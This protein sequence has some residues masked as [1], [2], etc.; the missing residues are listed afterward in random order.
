MT[1]WVQAIRQK[2]VLYSEF[3]KLEHTLFALPFALSAMVLASR[4]WPDPATVFWVI[5]AM[6]G[7]RTYAM[8]VNRIADAAL[9]AQNPRTKD[10]PLPSGRMDE[11]EAWTL[12]LSGLLVLILAVTFLPPICF[13]LLPVAWWILTMYSFTKRFSYLSHAVLGL[14]LGASAIGGW[15]AVE[16]QWSWMAVLFGLAVLF[17]VAGFDII[18]ACLDTRFDREVGLQ[19]VPA[20]F[21]IPTALLISRLCH[22][23]ALLFLVLTGWQ[24][25][26]HLSGMYWLAVLLTTMMLI[27]EHQLVKESDLSRVNEAFFAVNGL[28]SMAM[29]LMIILDRILLLWRS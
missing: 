25:V 13:A 3:V 27:Y 5:V 19:S 14:A 4:A 15:L 20:R 10:R 21:G 26:G 29:F 17:W 16:G 2:T 28:I 24:V 8:G 6:V 22:G 23:A 11:G 12:M 7:G 1:N 18:Y 9:D